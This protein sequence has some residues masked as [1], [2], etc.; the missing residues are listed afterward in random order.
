MAAAVLVIG[1]HALDEVLG[2]GG[3]M[4]GHADA[5]NP[6]QTLVLCGDGTGLDAKRRTAAAEAASIL[7]SEPPRF[8]GFPEN[9]SDTVPL[10]RIVEVIE[11]TVAEL[12]PATVYVSHGGNLNVDHQTA[13]RA[14]AT[15]L[16][17]M[18][19][20]PVTCF[21]A[22]E[23]ASSTDW[24]PPGF[25]EVFQP[26]HFVEI[27]AMMERK[28]QAL[29]AYAFD[30]RVAPHARSIAAVENLARIRGATVGMVAAEAFVTLRQLRRGSSQ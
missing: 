1:P 11:R 20:N 8:A 3:T 27:T 23:I 28:R 16:R 10:G 24:A 18:P 7:G 22:Y 2:C 6:V 30:M 13:F 17:P 4:A 15:A 25:G 5:G 26:N 21:Y 12:R 9:R 14:A 29:Q 19:G